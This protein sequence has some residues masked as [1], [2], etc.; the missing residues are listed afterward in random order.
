M[1]FSGEALS[2]GV[3]EKKLQGMIVR[4]FGPAKTIA[5]CFKFPNKIGLE[6]ALEALRDCYRQKKATMDE[7]FMAARVCR[8]ARIMQPYLESLA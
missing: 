8:V 6:V 2:Y 4:V 5:D 1:H 7:L 3:K